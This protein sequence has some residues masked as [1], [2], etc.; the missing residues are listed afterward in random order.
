MTELKAFCDPWEDY[1]LLDAGGGKKLERFGDQILIRPEVNAYFRSEKIFDDWRKVADWEF[2]SGK[3]Q[4]GKW[5]KLSAKA[6]DNWAL[7]Y[8]P[9]R[10][11]LELTNFK[12]IGVFPEQRINWD[13]IS[14]KVEKDSSFLN[15]FA[16]TGAASCV[17]RYK[18]AD[19]IHVDSVKQLIS[20]AGRNMESSR[21]ANI[22]WVHE[23]ALRF[24][25]RLVK[26]ESKFDF[27]IMD[28][29][30]WGIGAKN[31]KWKLQDKLDELI[32]GAA[33]ILNEN[34]TLIM[35][36]YSPQ[37]DQEMLHELANLY[38]PNMNFQIDQIWMR[39]KGGK[40]LYFS[41]RLILNP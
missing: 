28:P 38:F 19:T 40:E 10:L 30:A 2:I 14:S 13:I 23:D 37:V 4:T 36:T 11:Q 39:T 16:Y 34:G 29:P 9:L 17:A 27:I 22:R 26:R 1:E 15:L 12:H 6:P 18:G 8:G 25:N 24:L 5:K 20:W 41:D 35:N 31:E 33:S 32:S 7:R 21:L 3:G